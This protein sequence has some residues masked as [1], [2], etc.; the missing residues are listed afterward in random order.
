MGEEHH[1]R[2]GP[3]RD[4]RLGRGEEQRDHRQLLPRRER[5]HN[6]RICHKE[7]Q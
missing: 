6:K 2:S 3:W 1:N 5:R 4:N 7:Q